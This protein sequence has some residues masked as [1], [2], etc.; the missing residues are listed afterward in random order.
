LNPPIKSNQSNQ[1]QS[2]P[3]NKR[4][5]IQRNKRKHNDEQPKPH[6]RSLCSEN[7]NPQMAPVRGEASPGRVRIQLDAVR[8]KQIKVK[9]HIPNG[10]QAAPRND[11]DQAPGDHGVQ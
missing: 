7:E 6:N 8:A 10:V 4:K 1:S 2:K 9:C 11:A 5:Q 3:A